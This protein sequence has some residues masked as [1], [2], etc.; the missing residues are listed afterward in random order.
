M[1]SY[2]LTVGIAMVLIT[3]LFTSGS[4]IVEDQHEQTARTQLSIVGHQVA[5]SAEVADQLVRSTDSAPSQLTLTRSLP[6]RIAG[7]GYRLEIAPSGDAVVVHMMGDDLSV[8]TR[9]DTETTVTGSAQGGKIEIA[10]SSG[11]LVISNG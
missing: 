4:A 11:D 2:M 5:G 1:I 9:I 8:R 7:S 10:Y 3:G 6:D